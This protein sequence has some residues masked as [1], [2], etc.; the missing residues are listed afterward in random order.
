MRWQVTVPVGLDDAGRA[1]EPVNAW[2]RSSRSG[3]SESLPLA[4]DHP[5]SRERAAGAPSDEPL[6]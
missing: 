2:Y 1:L 5:R 3:R 4:P 6:T